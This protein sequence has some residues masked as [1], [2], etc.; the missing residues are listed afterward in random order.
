MD[1]VAAVIFN[2][3]TNIINNFVNPLKV[4]SKV[5]WS[6]VDDTPR[7]KIYVSKVEVQITNDFGEEIKKSMIFRIDG[8]G[9]SGYR[10]DV[11]TLPYSSWEA[12]DNGYPCKTVKDSKKL[13]SLW[14]KA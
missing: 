4:L 3:L 11:K 13:V 14:L 12:I 9:G 6:C 10:V 5:K 7:N 8:R 2:N 1:Y